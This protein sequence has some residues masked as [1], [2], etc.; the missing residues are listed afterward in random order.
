VLPWSIHS[1]GSIGCFVSVE[2]IYQMGVSSFEPIGGK[3]RDAIMADLALTSGVPTASIVPTEGLGYIY[4]TYRIAIPLRTFT[5]HY[6]YSIEEKNWMQFDTP[7]LLQTGRCEEVWTGVLASLPI[8]AQ[9]PGT[10]V[11]VGGGGGGGGGGGF[12]GGGGGGGT[13][14]PMLNF[15]TG[16]IGF[17]A[18]DP[19]GGFDDPSASSFY[20]FKVEDVIQ[21]RTATVSRVIFTYRDLGLAKAIFVLTGT[22]DNKVVGGLTGSGSMQIVSLGNVLA[23]G[24]L[25]TQFVD[26][27]LT[28]QNIQL[29]IVRA[30]GSGPV[31]IAK[32]L[33]CG[34]VEDAVYG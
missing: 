7:G 2:Q 10:G 26:I 3:A 33:M 12:G 14:Y 22:Q 16:I 27:S 20:N 30:A 31:S 4:L 13:L 34:R 8:A 15:A 1:Y 11:G 29:Q 25:M 28:A 24:K 9:P 21:G 23:T 19:S 17:F 6:W 32:V 5:R 18:F